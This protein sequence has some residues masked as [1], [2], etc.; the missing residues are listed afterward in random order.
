MTTWEHCKPFLSFIKA[1]VLANLPPKQV[2][3]EDPT[4]TTYDFWDLRLLKAYH[5]AQD[6]VRDGV[7]VWW[8]ESDEVVFEV[9]RRISRSRAATDRAEKAESS[10][11]K[12][13]PPGRYYVPV[14]KTRGDKPL[15]TFNAWIEEQERKRGKK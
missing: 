12:S 10:G 13:P 6:F 3:F 1:A 5:F 4:H 8:D 15:P 11:D 7:P 9:E 2:I 14:P